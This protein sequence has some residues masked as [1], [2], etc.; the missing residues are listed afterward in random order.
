MN[1]LQQQRARLFYLFVL[2]LGLAWIWISA[3]TSNMVSTRS[4]PA[5]QKDFLAPAISLKSMTGK[6]YQLSNFRGKVVLVNFWASWCPPCKAEMPA[7][8][9]IYRR[10]SDKGLV[11]LAVDSTIQDKASDVANF[12]KTNNLSFPVLMDLTGLATKTYR[13]QSLPSTYFIDKQ[14]I[15]RQIELGGPMSEAYLE[16]TI[17]QLLEDKP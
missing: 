17:N 2:I 7:I 8:E 10:Y 3:S 16:S 6:E 1:F 9:S 12:I 14:G 13:I 15:I 11:V 4:I 5:P